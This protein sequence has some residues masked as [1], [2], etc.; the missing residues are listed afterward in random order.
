MSKKWMDAM[1]IPYP[2]NRP[3]RTCTFECEYPDG[4]T[5]TEVTGEKV[6]NLTYRYLRR[7]SATSITVSASPS[8]AYGSDA[9]YMFSNCSS[10]T[11][12]TLPEGFGA[13]ITN[14]LYMF[15]SCSSLTSLTLPEGFGASITNAQSMFYNCSSLTSLTLPEGFGASITIAR[16][17]FYNCSS[18]TSLTLPEGF[19]ASIVSALSM[20]GGCTR[21]ATING[22]LA[23]KAS[24]D[25]SPTAL[26]E[27]SLVRVLD[28]LQAVSGK[29]LTLGETLKA[30][31]A[32]DAGKAAL[33]GAEARGWT[34]K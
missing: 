3:A 16:C 7:S 14:A 17:M 34:I 8:A 32:S 21:L 22:G 19:G 30:K 29:K 10:L 18:L 4:S 26:D 23:M 33:A 31:L 24:F 12:L 11:S 9:Q 28:S 20:F 5:S 2:P 15:S 25:L 6:V 13:S 1:I 27:A